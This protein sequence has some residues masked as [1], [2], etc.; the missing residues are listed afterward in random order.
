REWRRPLGRVLALAAGRSR[1]AA[2][3]VRRYCKPAVSR[4]GRARQEWSIQVSWQGSPW[5][6]AVI[7]VV[8]PG[9]HS[10]PQMRKAGKS[11]GGWTI[12]RGLIYLVH[13]GCGFPKALSPEALSPEALP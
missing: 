10:T 3:P 8:V 6:N 7:D 2:G 5:L 9:W 11:A 4:P 13:A 1:Q 12:R